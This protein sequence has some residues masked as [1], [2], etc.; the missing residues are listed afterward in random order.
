MLK[1]IL[2]I[3]IVVV[4][5]IAVVVLFFLGPILK[6][7]TSRVATSVMGVAV[8]LDSLSVS[9]FRGS[10]GLAGI[11]IAN[12]DGYETS[13]F[14]SLDSIVA[15]AGIT[16]FLGKTISIGKIVIDGMN[17]KIET[18]DGKSNLSVILDN[19]EKSEGSASKTTAEDSG[20][21]KKFRIAL[22]QLKNVHVMVSK[23]IIKNLDLTVGDF[24][25]RNLG[26]DDNAALLST[27]LKNIIHA[28]TAEIAKHPET[29]G[30]DL[31][32]NIFN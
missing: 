23:G 6:Y 1:W 12:P 14:S 18:K 9:P 13:H 8:S 11:N 25:I 20:N 26:T 30:W 27:V 10:I 4:I 15:S 21:A 24:E 17:V 28:L 16:S 22:I 32:K 29:L 31:L 19:I 3:T 7:P 5:L 2:S